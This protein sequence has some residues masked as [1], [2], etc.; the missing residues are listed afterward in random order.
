MK[1]S[2]AR[3]LYAALASSLA[4]AGPADAQSVADVE[5]R[6]LNS[7]LESYFGQFSR[8]CLKLSSTTTAKVQGSAIPQ[9]VKDW[10]QA[11]FEK[12]VPIYEGANLR[13]L[14]SRIYIMKNNQPM[15]VPASIA[16]PFPQA[17]ATA[18]YEDDSNFRRQH[19]CTTIFSGKSN[20]KVNFTLAEIRSVLDG[21]A[22][23]NDT[24]S[25]YA[26]SGTFYSP[27]AAALGLLADTSFG[28]SDVDPF[29][30]YLALWRWY[31]ENPAMA[32]QSADL[33]IYG[34]LKG[35]ALY[36]TSGITQDRLLAGS[37]SI[38]LSIPFLSTSNKA[39]GSVKMEM[40]TFENQFG[41]AVTDYDYSYHLKTL[42]SPQFIADRAPTLGAFTP[43][44]TNPKRVSQSSAFMM[45][46]DLDGVPYA[47]CRD[48][49]FRLNAPT[50]A[51][52]TEGAAGRA[53]LN[54]LKVQSVGDPETSRKCRFRVTVTPPPASE[55]V[56][57]TE[58]AF[59]VRADLPPN[60]GAKMPALVFSQNS[61][62][63]DLRSSIGL[64]AGSGPAGVVLPPNEGTRL[65]VTYRV[66]ETDQR[67]TNGIIHSTVAPRMTCGTAAPR[68]I[69]LQP[70]EAVL[71]RGAG[72]ADV[73]LTIP[74][75]A[76]LIPA[77]AATPTPDPPIKCQL[78]GRLS[79]SVEASGAEPATLG[80][81]T[82]VF[83]ASRAAA[84]LASN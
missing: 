6:P 58:V 83:T 64:N 24:Q 45:E 25:L 56:S 84:K 82:F 38:G 20:L 28:R 15:R 69:S 12:P 47:F 49:G 43:L 4:V 52:T 10:L 68:A 72:G 50:A 16:T 53:T 63:V 66:R 59:S 8:A 44:E 19:N 21:A 9:N 71:V 31:Q 78:D 62:L 27:V 39:E 42:R 2:P 13:N 55:T 75:P 61:T 76:D 77:Q 11:D 41:A 23:N 74:L 54:E 1:R 40:K 30:V 51:D 5:R 57:A 37:A 26:Y 67:R 36:R 17:A 70:G 46:Y 34:T 73:T 14:F 79:L 48:L 35:V 7:W 29:S 80:L 18:L 32:A 60:A 65:T 81:P 22:T 3:L 33:R